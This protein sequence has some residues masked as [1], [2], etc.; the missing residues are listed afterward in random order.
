M[1]DRPLKGIREG[2]SSD[3]ELSVHVCEVL[4]QLG[5]SQTMVKHRRESWREGAAKWN[6]K[7]QNPTVIIAGSK[8][9]GLT[10]PNESDTDR[11]FQDNYTVCR[12]P[13]DD[14]L[15]LPDTHYEFTM[16]REHC[17]PGHFRLELK[18]TGTSENSNIQQALFVHEDGR[19]FISSEKYTISQIKDKTKETISGPALKEYNE[20]YIWDHVHAFPCT[21]QQQL[22]SEW[23]N[24]PRHHNWPT[25]DM[26]AEVSKLQAQMVPVG[27]KSSEHKDI[28]WRVCFIPG[29]QRLT[30][31]WNENHFKIYI[32]LKWINNSH[33]KPIC[34]EIS[35]YILKN[36]MLWYT[37]Q[38]PAKIFTKK[39]LLQNVFSCLKN[40]Q[41]AIQASNHLPYYMIPARNLLSG[42]VSPE[43]QQQLIAKLEE[44]IQEGPCTILRCP[45]VEAARQMSSVKLAE[46]GCWR[47]KLEKL[48]L[49]RWR[50][51]ETY[52]R[53]GMKQEEIGQLARGN[54]HYIRVEEKMNDMV[55]PQWRDNEGGEIRADKLNKKIKDALS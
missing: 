46:K 1:E 25:P 36:I 38:N 11:M 42:R 51:W 52:W 15:T 41:E 17:H 55:W 23:I 26:I 10:P 13:E 30:D 27:C 44:L 5:Y 40:L 53:P 6:E 18:H 7:G 28:E 19:T 29:E 34:D 54:P 32:L 2:K 22:L 4:D 33:L 43:Q 50:I 14:S 20:L 45:K 48:G 21:S 8:G 39:N 37:E 31:S 16:D 49:Q 35:S 24:R 47:D 9:E 3:E 12:I